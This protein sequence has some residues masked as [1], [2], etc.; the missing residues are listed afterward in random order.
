MINFI[1]RKQKREKVIFSEHSYYPDL[2]SKEPVLLDLGGCYGAFSKHFLEKFP[3]SK[4]LVVEA[5]P[6]NFKQINIDSKQC[7]ILNKAI[8]L[9]KGHI[10]FYEDENSSQN[11]S[12]LFNYFEGVRHEIET[13]SLEALL[14]DF[15]HVDLVKMDIE[16][17]EWDILLNTPEDE[18]LKI[19]QLTVEFHDFIE[20]DKKR[21]TLQCVK[22]LKRLGYNLEFQSTDYMS[23]SKYYD[24]L[25]YKTKKKTCLSFLN[26][27]LNQIDPI[28]K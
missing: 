27:F 11:G 10:V 23:G 6:T 17:A 22:K 21:L 16:G 8:S 19:E 3:A 28:K 26:S 15:T 13:I 24:C 5:N 14:K 1:K 20:K 2:I 7:E 12:V 4:I 25:F 9:K 18:L